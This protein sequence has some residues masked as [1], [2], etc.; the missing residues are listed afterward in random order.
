MQYAV[1]S[2]RK[3]ESSD[4]ISY[5][6]AFRFL[7]TAH[8]LL[9]AARCSPANEI[10]NLSKVSEGCVR[11]G[12]ARAADFSRLFGPAGLKNFVERQVPVVY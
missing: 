11:D 12:R 4:E 1:G 10:I 2:K 9:S 7:F 5:V 8:C 6:T 3:T